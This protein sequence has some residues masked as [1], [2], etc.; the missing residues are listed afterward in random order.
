MNQSKKIVI[1][2]TSLAI[3]LAVGVGVAAAED[4]STGAS[5]AEKIASKFNLN[6]DD[7][8]QVIDE[9]REARHVERQKKS[10]E[11]LQDAVD[12]GRLT[13]E[14]KDMIVSKMKEIESNREPKREEMNNKTEEERRAA[15]KIEREALQKWAEENNIP[16]QYIMFG[17]RG[18]GPGGMHGDGPP[19][20]APAEN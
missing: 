19:P 18:H 15:M 3:A 2:V 4:S 16:T 5:L 6:K 8:Q 1:G 7:V 11:R 12:A 10:E 14:Q 13:S 20:D 9:D 17:G